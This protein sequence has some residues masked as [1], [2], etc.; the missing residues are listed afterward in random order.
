MD[1][2]EAQDEWR[3]PSQLLKK[4]AH[5]RMQAVPISTT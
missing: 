1:I 4:L 3:V 2:V 5:R